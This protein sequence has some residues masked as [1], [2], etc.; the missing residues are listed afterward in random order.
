MFVS[1][2]T[3]YSLT[4]AQLPFGRDNLAAITDGDFVGIP[5]GGGGGAAAA[6]GGGAAAAAGGAAGGGGGPPCYS[7]CVRDVL[8]GLLRVDCAERLSASDGV[9]LIETARAEAQA[10][11]QRRAELA[12]AE[13]EQ[14]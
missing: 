7:E 8:S 13:R 12:Q 6:G 2:L 10:A 11:E 5:G 4:T 1:G 9:Q 14:R 3:L